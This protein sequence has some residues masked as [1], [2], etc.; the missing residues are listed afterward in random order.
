M[1]KLK[2]EMGANYSIRLIWQ[3]IRLNTIL[4]QW[5]FRQARR[6]QNSYLAV[7]LALNPIY[8]NSLQ[9]KIFFPM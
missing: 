4:V 3:H 6:L 9:G 2:W 7:H 1:W 8:Q 5:Y